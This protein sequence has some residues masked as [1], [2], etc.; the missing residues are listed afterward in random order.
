MAKIILT[1][2]LLVSFCSLAFAANG[3]LYS[4]WDVLEL[5]TC[6]SAW[7]IKR[8]IDKGAEFKFFPKGAIITEGTPFDTPDAKFRRTGNMSTFES[9]LAEYKIADKRLLELG[10][11]VR[12]LEINY[13][14]ASPSAEQSALKEKI[15][16]IVKTENDNYRAFEESFKVFDEFYKRLPEQ[17]NKKA[18]AIKSPAY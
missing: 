11:I 3:H 2:L 13:W 9:L 7:L 5:D 17:A 16:G 6:A 4:T 10:E 14:A 15:A 8:F 12:A 18:F 1:A